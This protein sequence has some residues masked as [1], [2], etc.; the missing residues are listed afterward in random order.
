MRLLEYIYLLLRMALVILVMAS[1]VWIFNHPVE[2]GRWYGRWQKGQLIEFN[3][4]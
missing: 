2:S 4:R 1:V 3:K